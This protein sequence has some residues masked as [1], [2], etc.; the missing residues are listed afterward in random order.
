MPTRRL[1]QSL[2]FLLA[3]SVSV[4]IPGVARAM[5]QVG[6]LVVNGQ[7][8]IR[9]VIFLSDGSRSPVGAAV[10]NGIDVPYEAVTGSLGNCKVNARINVSGVGVASSSTRTPIFPANFKFGPVVLDE[11]GAS[12]CIGC[13]VAHLL[14]PVSLGVTPSSLATVQSFPQVGPLEFWY[15][16]D[17]LAVNPDVFL[18]KVDVY[19]ED[20]AVIAMIP[21]L[22]K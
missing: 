21:V 8:P 16:P 5:C 10:V 20:V 13:G 4:A 7:L 1:L 9:E 2:G 11:V 12:I 14:G 3:L 22:L 19:V 15:R 18:T 17:E 6:P